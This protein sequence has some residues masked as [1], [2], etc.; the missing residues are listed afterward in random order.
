MAVVQH[1]SRPCSARLA[2]VSI[3]LSLAAVNHPLCVSAGSASSTLHCRPCAQ[4]CCLLGACAREHTKSC[5]QVETA[6][7]AAGGTP[8]DGAAAGEAADDAVASRVHQPC[9]FQELVEGCND[10]HC[11]HSSLAA[12]WL[13]LLAANR[14]CCVCWLPPCATTWVHGAAQMSCSTA[15]RA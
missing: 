11:Q 4:V 12:C 10:C 5:V 1:A 9:V 6:V 2:C 13:R 14:A 7:V 3:L 8:A 15:L